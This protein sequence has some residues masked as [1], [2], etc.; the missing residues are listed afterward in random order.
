MLVYISGTLPRVPN[1]SFDNKLASLVHHPIDKVQ[2]FITGVIV[3][4]T[5]RITIDLYYLI[6][7]KMR[8]LITSV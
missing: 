3:L 7:P 4:P 6:P 1:F 8:N 5:Q 2:P